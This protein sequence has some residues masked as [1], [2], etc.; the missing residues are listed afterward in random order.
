MGAALQNASGNHAWQRRATGAKHGVAVRR[1]PDS[2]Q[3]RCAWHL[4]AHTA[5]RFDLRHECLVMLAMDAA[6]W[7][8][9]RIRPDFLAGGYTT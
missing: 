2:F 6:I 4:S 9:A 8:Y 5:Q 3:R 1:H 7:R